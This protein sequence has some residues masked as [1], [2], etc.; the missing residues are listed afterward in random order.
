MKRRKLLQGISALAAAPIMLRG[1]DVGQAFEL[2]N[3][4]YVVFLNA[5]LIDVEEFANTCK[6]FPGDTPVFPVYPGPGDIDEVVRIFKL[7]E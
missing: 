6:S 5:N 1:Q 3:S 2:P 7:E 4:R